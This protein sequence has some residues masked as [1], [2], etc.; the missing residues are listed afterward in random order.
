MAPPQS[1]EVFRFLRG[2][3]GALLIAS[4]AIFIA[5]AAWRFLS[6][7]GRSMTEFDQPKIV[8]LALE[9]IPLIRKNGQPVDVMAGEPVALKC[10]RVSPPEGQKGRFRYDFGDGTPPLEQP[11][12]DVVHAFQGAPGTIR[13]IDARYFIGDEQVDQ[14]RSEVRL[15]AQ[16][17][18]FRLR[19]FGTAQNEAIQSL[20]LPHEVIPYVEGALELDREKV[21]SNGYKVAFFTQRDGEDVLYLRVAPPKEGGQKVR[22]ITS[23]LKYFRD[24]GR[25]QGLAG[26]PDE[27]I[28]IGQPDDDRVLFHVYAGLFPNEAIDTLLQKCCGGAAPGVFENAGLKLDEVRALAVDGRVTE[29][30]RVV[31]VSK[32]SGA[33]KIVLPPSVAPSSAPAAPASAAPA[34]AAPTP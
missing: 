18:F 4:I 34:S 24:Y 3:S 11:D 12:C 10:Q 15:T 1:I 33:A 29:P 13:T 16:G 31:R 27:P 2:R 7:S 23:P 6:R 32:E 20:S 9:G 28:T 22:A 21:K 8:V 30:L 26:I 19:G 17:P 25:F 5:F 14:Y